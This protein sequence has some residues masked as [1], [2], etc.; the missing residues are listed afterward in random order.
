[1]M[2][3][4]MMMMMMMMMDVL[5][6]GVMLKAKS[7][8]FLPECVALKKTKPSHFT[9]WFQDHKPRNC[10]YF[11]GLDSGL[12]CQLPHKKHSKN[13]S[14]SSH[15][16]KSVWILALLGVASKKSLCH[17]RKPQNI[18]T[19]WFT[20]IYYVPPKSCHTQHHLTISNDHLATRVIRFWSMA[21]Q[22]TSP[23]SRILKGLRVN[24]PQSSGAKSH[25]T[26][27]PFQAVKGSNRKHTRKTRN[28]A[29]SRMAMCLKIKLK[30]CIDERNSSWRVCKL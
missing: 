25:V 17:H 18:K 23:S 19:H 24:W 10:I 22:K 7:S 4:M 21:R 1:M 16:W 27:C 20:L 8:S 26:R 30:L 14:C 12:I 6:H 5:L 3:M 13:K 29:E 28:P 11:W 9:F 2:I 15:I